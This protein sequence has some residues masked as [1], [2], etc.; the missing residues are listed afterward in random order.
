MPDSV[1]SPAPDSTTTSPPA[2]SSR[3][4]SAA[5]GSRAGAALLTAPWC[6]ARGR[7]SDLVGQRAAVALLDPAAQAAVAPRR[8]LDEHLVQRVPLVVQLVAETHAG[9]LQV[10]S[11]GGVDEV[12]PGAQQDAVGTGHHREQVHHVVDLGLLLE[13]LLD[14]P[15]ESRI[16]LLADEQ[17]LAGPAQRE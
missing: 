17:V 4:P 8:R 6:L 12:D 1:D 13:P 5:V 3:S 7:A 15:H 10:R 9:V 14:G 2:T 11:A 16:G